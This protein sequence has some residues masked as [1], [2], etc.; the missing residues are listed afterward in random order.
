MPAVTLNTCMRTR[1]LEVLMSVQV[2]SIVNPS[3][4]L[5]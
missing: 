5:Y 2:H 1:V 4:S 3:P